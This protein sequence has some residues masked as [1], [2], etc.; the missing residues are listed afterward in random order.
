MTTTDIFI[1][2]ILII[3][4]VYWGYRLFIKKDIYA[5]IPE[6]WIYIVRVLFYLVFFT[7]I[8]IV[9][10]TLAKLINHLFV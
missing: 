1:A 2:V 3:F 10:W 6:D 8:G 4:I 9:I 7:A 5:G